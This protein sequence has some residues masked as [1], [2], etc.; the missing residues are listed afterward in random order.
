MTVRK[1]ELRRKIKNKDKEA[2]KKDFVVAQA[3]IN[4]LLPLDTRL[5]KFNFIEQVKDYILEECE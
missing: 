1:N 4:P 5:E 2:L 3:S